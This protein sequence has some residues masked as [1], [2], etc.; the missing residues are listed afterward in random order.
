MKKEKIEQLRH[1]SRKLI[2]ELGILQLDQS[3]AHATPSHWHALIE[4]DKD[5]SITISKL[6]NL[7]LMSAPKVSR[8]T[9]SLAKEEL[10]ELR[11]GQDRRE[12]YLYLTAPGKTAVAKID[13]FSR[14]KI[15]DA[16]EFLNDADMTKIIDSI[17]KYSAALEKSRLLKE[18]VK[19]ATLPT[20]RTIRKQIINMIA[21]IQKGEFSIPITDET[22]ACI[23]KAEQDFY[24]NHSYNFWYA[25]DN[26]GKIIGSIG[27]K[28]IDANKGEIK[29]FFVAAGYRGKG[30]AQKLMTTLLNA[31]NKH[32]FQSLFLGTV[33]KLEAAQK[34]Y[35]RHGFERIERSALPHNFEV[36]PVD[37][38]FFQGHTEHLLSKFR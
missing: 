29:K 7:L 5:P 2:R 38:V 6:G 36:C 10:I 3:D 35:S 22:N 33:D 19:I 14:S 4:I 9:K 24:Y 15:Q 21:D 20:S 25:L 37:S 30:V 1:L 31:A 18:Q 17:D 16:F 26:E 27:L 28:K 8:L 32:G 23:L 13:D 12:K 34:F 11:T